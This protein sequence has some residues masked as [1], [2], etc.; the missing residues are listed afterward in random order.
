MSEQGTWFIVLNER[1]GSVAGDERAAAI[2][3][4][5]G[6]AGRPFELLRA[7]SP[8][9]LA[10][11]ARRAVALAQAHQGVVV[12]AGGDGTINTVAQAALGAGRP[13]GVLPQGTFNFT[14]RA[15]GLPSEPGAA[16][17]SLL[18]AT[19]VPVQVGVVNGRIFLVN[20]SLG[21][22]PRL[23]EDRERFKSRLGRSRIVAALAGLATLLRHAGELRLSVEVE[24]QPQPLRTPTLVVANNLLQLEELGLPEAEAV[25]TGQLAGFAVKPIGTW[26]L[27]WLAIRGALGRLGDAEEMHRFSFGRMVVRLRRSWR[28][29][30]VAVDGE[31]VWLTP[32]LV[33]TVAEQRLELLIPR[34]PRRAEV[35]PGDAGG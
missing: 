8:A 9:E 31:V 30:K 21:L 3:A 16:V 32:P 20:A 5:L 24:G 10:A 27:L 22:Y 25:R 12:A 4:A 23:V 6:E 18:D 33:F 17:R 2:Q 29:V 26:G 15:H 1:S 7:G 11:A 19:P 35:R 28:R 34:G 14:G 13:F